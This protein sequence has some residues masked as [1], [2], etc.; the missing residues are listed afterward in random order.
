M[1]IGVVVIY[2]L[3][4]SIK[5]GRVKCPHSVRFEPYNQLQPTSLKLKMTITKVYAVIGGYDYEGEDFKS[6][7]LFD[8]FSAANSYMAE[9]ENGFYDYVLL[10][11]REVNIESAL[12]SIT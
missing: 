11:T 5:G 9:L 6:L 4:D 7:R 8:C 2:T 1:L 12:V 3:A 10:D